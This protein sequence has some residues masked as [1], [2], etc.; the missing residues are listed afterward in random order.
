M[1]P[2]WDISS[3]EQRAAWDHGEREAVSHMARQIE[4]CLATAKLRAP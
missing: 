4:A 2:D 1:R 3:L